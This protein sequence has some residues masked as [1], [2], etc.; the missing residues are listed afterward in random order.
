[1][2]AK[3]ADKFDGVLL[4]IAQE[5]EGGVQDMLDIIFSFLAR[6]TDFY[7]G[8]T[9]SA[10]EA[11]IMDKFR[12]H[13]ATARE[14]KARKKAE[15]EEKDRKMRERRQKE[16]SEAAAVAAAEPAKIC[17]VTEEEAAKIEKEEKEKKEAGESS[18]KTA[19]EGEPASKKEKGEEEED[20]DDKGKMKPN[21]RNGADLPGYSWGQTLEEIELRVPLGGVYKGKDVEVSI[22]K[23]HLRVS[24]RGQPPIIDA[25]FP[26]EVKVEESAWI[27]EDKRSL[28]LNIEKKNKMEWW[29]RLVTTDPEI[30]TKKVQ[31]ENSKLSDLD[32]ETRG[33]VE[34]M[35]YDQRQKEM[36]LPTSDEQKKQDV[37]KQ[38]MTQ[39]PEMDFSKCKFN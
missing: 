13:G 38:F 37:L 28:L 17:E 24:V 36:G 16:E 30:N 34:K 31:P 29:N 26:K 21:A 19:E 20:E 33:M 27:I 39:H 25:D 6:K 11:L 7:T 22:E 8:S 9:E 5:C 10:A 1:M 2:A 23:K 35:M 32:G 15:N 3:A 14:E 4:S 12:K 18:T